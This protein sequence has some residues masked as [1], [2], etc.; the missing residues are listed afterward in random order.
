MQDFELLLKA[1][2]EE[3][4]DFSVHGALQA[5]DRKI[6]TSDV[7]HAILNHQKVIYLAKE[8]KYNIYGEYSQTHFLLVSCVYYNGVLV[9]TVHK[10]MKKRVK[11]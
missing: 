10:I 3:R 2:Q 6:S 11:I 8:N 4:I 9:I 5:A 1:A 7:A